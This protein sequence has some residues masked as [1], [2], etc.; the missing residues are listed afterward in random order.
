MMMSMTVMTFIA[1]SVSSLTPFFLC[2][3]TFFRGRI[4]LSYTYPMPMALPSGA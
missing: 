4:A 1:I 3:L 2:C